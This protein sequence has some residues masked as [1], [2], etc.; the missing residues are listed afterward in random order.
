[1]DAAGDRLVERAGP[2]SSAAVAGYLDHYRIPWRTYPDGWRAEV[3]LAA[4]GWM[5]ALGGPLARGFLLQV[6]YGD[7]ARRLYTR[8]RRRGTLAVYTHHRLGERPLASPGQQDLTAHVN[9][10]ALIE[11]GRMMG[12]RLA[13]LTTQRAFLLRAGIQQEVERRAAEQFPLADVA[14]ASDAGQRDYLRRAALRAAMRTLISAEGLGG[15]H[16]LVQQRGVP[17]TGR[18]LSGLAGVLPEA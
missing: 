13:G 8:D 5:L 18:R 2:P 16:A 3:C 1:M 9:F 7:R 10:S 17:G 4:E 15:F 11:L 12:L 6:D 14:R